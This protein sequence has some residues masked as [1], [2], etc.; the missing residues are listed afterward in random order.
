MSIGPVE[1]VLVILVILLV[2]GGRRL[3]EI[4]RGLG[5]MVR[6]FKETTHDN[7]PTKS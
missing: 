7:K 4:G 5:K 6:D 2:F 1:M 3:P